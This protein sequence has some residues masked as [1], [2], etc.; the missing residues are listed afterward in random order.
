MSVVTM[1]SQKQ[2]NNWTSYVIL[3]SRCNSFVFNFTLKLWFT[4]KN[5]KCIAGKQTHVYMCQ[6]N[7]LFT[8]PLYQKLCAHFLNQQPLSLRRE[9][10]ELA[11]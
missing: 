6:F 1:G 8:L 4:N 5:E 3:V 9:P 11:K 2:N 10:P 7:P